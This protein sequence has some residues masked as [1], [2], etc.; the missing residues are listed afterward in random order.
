MS[1]TTSAVWTPTPSYVLDGGT[2]TVSAVAGDDT[3]YDLGTLPANF[4]QNTYGLPWTVDL[5]TGD[6][7]IR[8]TYQP[9][10]GGTE[11]D[12]TSPA[13]VRDRALSAAETRAE[14]RCR[15]SRDGKQD[16]NHLHGPGLRTTQRDHHRR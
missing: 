15:H 2:F 10:D 7:S 12:G 1:S 11:V 13:T 3:T 5:P 8:V 14:L 4:A 16:G 9:S 6:Y